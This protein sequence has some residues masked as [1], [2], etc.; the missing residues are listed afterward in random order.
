MKFGRSLSF[1]LCAVVAPTVAQADDPV[2]PYAPQPSPTTQQAPATTTPNTTTTVVTPAPQPQPQQ[3]V[4][5]VQ[6]QQQP[7]HTTVVQRE[8][9][10]SEVY[11]EWNAPVFATGAL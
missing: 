2:D 7:T 9:E 4:V 3:P 10:G 11:D 5:V 1:V 6:P 8:P